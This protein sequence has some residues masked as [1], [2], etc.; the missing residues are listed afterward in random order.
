MARIP[1]LLTSA[2]LCVAA[3][4]GA[5]M[6][7][8][9][10]FGFYFPYFFVQS[11]Y[12]SMSTGAKLALSLLFNMAM[13]FGVNVIGLYEGTGQCCFVLLNACACCSLHRRVSMQSLPSLD[14]LF[15]LLSFYC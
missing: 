5:A 2:C 7:G 10:F 12:E 13:A 11:D 8:I 14:F 4:V 15:S 1:L 3:N 9:L 6:A